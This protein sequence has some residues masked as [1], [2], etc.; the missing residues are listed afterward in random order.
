MIR[1]VRL[2]AY[3]LLPAEL[4]LLTCLA[5]GVRIPTPLLLAAEAAVAA[6]LLAEAYVLA[7]LF[8]TARASGL[9]RR[10]ALHDAVRQAVPAP[11][12]GLLAHEIRALASLG[13]WAVRRRHGVGPGRLGFGY[14]RDQ[15]SMMLIFLF[16]TVLEG[17]A[18]AYLISWPALHKIMIVLHVYSVLLILGMIAA[19]H[20]RPHVIGAGELRV[21]HGAAFDL[22][23]PLRLV[24]GARTENRIHD[25]GMVR[26]GEDRADIIVAAQTN[27]TVELTEPVTVTKALGGTGRAS[28]IR[29]KADDAKSFVR[30]LSIQAQAARQ[31]SEPIA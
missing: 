25:G 19:A 11:V 5:A 18:L 6:V 23:V 24:A 4:V 31:E 17:V 10:A 21:R 3:L 2:A 8:R 12:R 30:E 13:L 29:L 27:V 7:T 15:N 9:P 1:A 28:V 20:T 16:V 14:S 26:L 22:R